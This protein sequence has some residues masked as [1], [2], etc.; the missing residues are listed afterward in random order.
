MRPSV[1]SADRPAT[2]IPGRVEIVRFS[3]TGVAR[4][5]IAR[6][7]GAVMT[8]PMLARSPLP[9]GYPGSHALSE[10]NQERLENARRAVFGDPDW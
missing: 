3:E 1:L 7:S 2:F 4:Y 6:R 9:S 10:E 8:W 5:A